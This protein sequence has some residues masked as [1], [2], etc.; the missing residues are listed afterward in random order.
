M[1]NLKPPESSC[2]SSDA[3][4]KREKRPRDDSDPWN[5][6]WCLDEHRRLEM[7]GDSEVV[8]N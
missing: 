2:A 8:I 7:L 5:L 4:V 6:A 3:P 1:L